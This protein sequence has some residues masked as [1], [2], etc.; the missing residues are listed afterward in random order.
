MKW[1]AGRTTSWNQDCWEI[2]SPFCFYPPEMETRLQ[3]SEQPLSDFEKTSQ[4]NFSYLKYQ[5]YLNHNLKLPRDPS[6]SGLQW[7]PA[8][9]FVIQ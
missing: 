1:Y 8:V 9:I 7:K 2:L 4:G 5:N 6:F 3:K